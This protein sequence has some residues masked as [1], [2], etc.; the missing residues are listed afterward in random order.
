MIF[1]TEHNFENQIF[2]IFEE[3]H[4]DFGRFDIV[5]TAYFHYMYIVCA[6]MCK[7]IKKNLERHLINRVNF[8]GLKT[9]NRDLIKFVQNGSKT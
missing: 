2:A 8:C 3:V 4:D 7:A 9:L 6:F 5:K 1:S